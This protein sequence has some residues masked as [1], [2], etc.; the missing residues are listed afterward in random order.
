[1]PKLSTALEGSR[2]LQN[3]VPNPGHCTLRKKQTRGSVK[4]S[5]S[6]A[7]VYKDLKGCRHWDTGSA[8]PSSVGMKVSLGQDESQCVKLI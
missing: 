2:T 6:H 7:R 1:M 4:I 5:G 8:G 3:S